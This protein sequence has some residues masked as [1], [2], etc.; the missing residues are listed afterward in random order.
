MSVFDTL[1]VDAVGTM[2][3]G[4]RVDLDLLAATGSSDA[5]Y[6]FGITL[7]S[8]DER[9]GVLGF[10]AGDEDGVRTAQVFL[11]DGMTVLDLPDIPSTFERNVTVPIFPGSIDIEVSASA[12]SDAHSAQAAFVDAFNSAW[13]GISGVGYTSLNGYGYPGFAAAIPEPTPAALLLAGL[14]IVMLECRRRRPG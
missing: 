11:G 8:G 14:A 10:R 12:H 3:F 9:R 1:N 13:L 7:G 5:V 4:I 2:T 6:S